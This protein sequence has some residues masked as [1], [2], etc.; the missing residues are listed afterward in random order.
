MIYLI[1]GENTLAKDQKIADLKKKLISPDAV[2]F[3]YEVLDSH[4]L[5][6]DDL[7][8][9]LLALPVLAPKRLIVLH[10]INKLNSRHKDII[11][12]FAQSKSNS[13]ELILEEIDLDARQS[14]NKEITSLSQFLQFPLEPKKNVFDMTKAMS[15]RQ[16]VDALK[17]LEDLLD[18][19]EHPLKILGALVWFWGKSKERLSSEKFQKGLRALLQTDMNIKRTRLEP[20]HALEI[21]VIKLTSLIAY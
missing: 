16:P 20:Q 6:P 7:K 13:P 15:G 12:E 9:A 17:I 21:L 18:A 10:H 11:L 8:K 3:D 4:K 14:F 2:L 19:Q 5:D 1:V